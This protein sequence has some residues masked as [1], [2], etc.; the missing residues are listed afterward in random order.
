MLGRIFL[1]G[2]GQEWHRSS[3]ERGWTISRSFGTTLLS[4]GA[5]KAFQYGRI[6][7]LAID[8]IGLAGIRGGP[9]HPPAWKVLSLYW[10]FGMRVD[11][12]SLLSM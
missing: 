8:S 5:C 10:H 1:Y 9:E 7:L 2:T 11:R 6:E 3:Y 4:A 12:V